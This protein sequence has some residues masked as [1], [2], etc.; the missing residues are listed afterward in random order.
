VLSAALAIALLLFVAAARQFS[1]PVTSTFTST[2][3]GFQFTYPSTWT[4]HVNEVSVAGSDVFHPV[5]NVVELDA[6]G[7]PR[8]YILI[9]YMYNVNGQNLGDFID[10][11]SECDEI[12]GQP[13]QSLQVDGMSARVYRNINC[14][15]NGETRV[16]I[17][18]GL[19]GYNI[20]LH[21]K[22]VDETVLGMVLS[23]FV[24]LRNKQ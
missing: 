5:Q 14:N 4:L 15:S 19:T 1:T 12:L 3:G 24:R 6:P 16:Y 23:N 22:P 7:K 11:S 13:G 8:P 18:N 21:G 17:V 10:N 20:L 2:D 9:E